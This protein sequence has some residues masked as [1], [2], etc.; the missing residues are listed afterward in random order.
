MSGL[1]LRGRLV[2]L[3]AIRPDELDLVY[4]GLRRIAD[5]PFRPH[6]ARLRRRIEDSGLLVRGRLTLGVDVGGRL[7][8]DISARESPE[9]LPP[10]V[11]ELGLGLFDESDRGRGYGSEA[12]ALLTRS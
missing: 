11:F 2:T 9:A 8:G 1:V 4:E 3:R 6:R 12:V 5:T 7:V 10:G